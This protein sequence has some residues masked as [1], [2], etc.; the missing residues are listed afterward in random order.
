MSKSPLVFLCGSSEDLRDEREAALKTIH[1][2]NFQCR[3]METFGARVD[4][5]IQT[6][7][8]EVKESDVLV[9]IIGRRYGSINPDLGIS[10]SQAE[11]EEAQ[12][13]TKPCLIYMRDE[14]VPLPASKTELDSRKLLLL[15]SWQETLQTKHTVHRFQDCMDL[16]IQLASDL[17]RLKRE[18]FSPSNE[19][20]I[21]YQPAVLGIKAKGEEKPGFCTEV[22]NAGKTDISAKAERT[23]YHNLP[24]RSHT[25][26]VGREHLLQVLN[27][28][29]SFDFYERIITIT[30]IGGVGKTA[31][32]LEAAHY[33]LAQEHRDGDQSNPRFDLIL[34]ASAQI[35]ILSPHGIAE[36]Q[37][38]VR[39]IKTLQDLCHD[40][41]NVC[42]DYGLQQVE[43]C[44][45]IEELQKFLSSG[46][47]KTLLILDN[48]ETLEAEDT[49]HILEFLRKIKSNHIKIII[50]TRYSDRFDISL[51]QLTESATLEMIEN[52]LSEKDLYA[53]NEFKQELKRLSGGVPLAIQYAT[54]VLAL[55]GDPNLAIIR[56]NDPKGDLSVYCFEKLILE[57]EAKNCIAYTLLLALSLSPSGLTQDTILRIADI[58]FSQLNEAR[59]SLTL[60]CRCSL[61]Y[62][63]NKF[64]KLLPLT[65]EYILKILNACPIKETE[66]RAL[67]A[68]DYINCA[69]IN[70]G[71]DQGEWHLKYD[72]INNEW[73]NFREVFDWCQSM[74]K[75]EYAVSLWKH[76]HRFMYLYAY[77]TDRLNWSDWLINIS[78]KKGEKAFLAEVTTAKAWLT[79]LREGTDNLLRAEDLLKNAWN[80]KNYCKPY[81]SCT[82]ALNLAVVNS[83]K[84]DFIKSDYWFSEYIKLQ[85]EKKPFLTESNKKRLELRYLLY[86]GERFYR[87]GR[88][89]RADRIYRQTIKKAENINWLRFQVKAYERRALIAIREDRLEEA[90]SILQL[91]YPVMER[92]HD[93][94]RLAFF[95][96]DF[97]ELEWKKNNFV[98]AQFWASKASQIFLNLK[99][100][101]RAKAMKELIEQCEL[102]LAGP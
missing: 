82:I 80:L 44:K 73:K 95:Q 57:I 10:Y 66:L 24:P 28:R 81:I 96:R 71:E 98:D 78:H 99:M 47:F 32:A 49:H 67:W 46:K 42:M 74:E 61:V 83:R 89:L 58:N 43:P 18:H 40:I 70:G 59:N 85:R 55:E 64:Y 5:P 21:H 91:W 50:T 7:L 25:K 90:E 45:Q 48:L 4:I 30:G 53:T 27:E 72:V 86:Y 52:L 77:W 97:A 62:Q 2:L 100:A 6:C 38:T 34:F 39:P 63:E 26:L 19:L 65:R 79:L 94:R 23:I 31:L 13:L 60:L 29:I 15:T 88:Y 68:Q 51:P 33:H 36:I 75:Y 8:K 20:K 37:A 41:A 9:V 14:M 1:R 54:G 3:S 11:Y 102:K 92:N 56:L 12:R 17:S 84:E 16:A 87:E 69:Q 93:Y 76:L 101:A 22:V 35:N